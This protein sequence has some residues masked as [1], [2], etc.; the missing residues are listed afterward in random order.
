MTESEFFGKIRSALR[1]AFASWRP[2]TV[3][4]NRARRNSQSSNPRLQYEYQ[5]AHCERWFPRKEVY[6]DHIEPVGTLRKLEDIPSFVERLTQECDCAYQILCDGCHQ[7]KTNKENKDA[8][9]A[10]KQQIGTG[11]V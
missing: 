7:K 10:R 3:A 8:R 9:H 1:K 2:M 5:C 11:G 6:I 4:L